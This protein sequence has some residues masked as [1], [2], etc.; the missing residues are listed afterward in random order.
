MYDQVSRGQY[1]DYVASPAALAYAI[2]QGRI[3]GENVFRRLD[4]GET[5]EQFLARADNLVDEVM[6]YL[7]ADPDFRSRVFI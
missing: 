1:P 3:P 7:I 5:K 6:R 2:R 4:H